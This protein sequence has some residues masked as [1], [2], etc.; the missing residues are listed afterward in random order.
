MKILKID[1]CDIS[2]LCSNNP[3]IFSKID[4]KVSYEWFYIEI[5]KDDLHLVCILSYKDCFNLDK[6]SVEQQSIYFTLYKGKKIVAYSYVYFDDE[7][8]KNYKE[9]LDQWLSGKNSVFSFWIP[10]HSLKKFININI[11]YEFKQNSEMSKLSEN[12]EGHFWQFIDSGNNLSAV[13]NIYNV[14][15]EF[16]FSHLCKRNSFFFDYP[17]KLKL[18]NQN[19]GVFDFK[20]ASFYF[21][22]NYGYSPLYSIKEPWYWWHEII[23]N[24]T[25]VNYYF[26]HLESMYQVKKTNDQSKYSYTYEISN[27]KEINIIKKF[28]FNIFGIKYP[29]ILNLNKEIVYDFTLESAP[30]YHRVKSFELRSTLEVLYPKKIENLFNQTLIKSRKIKIIKNISSKNEIRSYLNFSQICKKITYNHGKSFYISSLVLGEKQRNSSYF[31]YVLCRLIDDAT[32]E[33]NCFIDSSKIGSTFSN[34]IL[35]YLWSECDLLSDD[36]IE[37]FIQHLSNKVFSLVNYDSAIDFILSAR[38][39]IK[40]LELEKSYFI[41]LINGQKMDENFVQ[42]LNISDLYLYCFRVAGVVGIMMAKIFHAKNNLIAM[43]A[44]EKLGCAMQI[45]NILRDIKE[46]YENNRIYIPAELFSKYKIENFSLL[47][48]NNYESIKK[49]NLINELVNLAILYYCEAIEG[50][51]YIPSFRARLCV[52][53]MIGVYGSILGKI[54]FDKSIVFK[55]RIVISHFKKLIIFFKILFGFHPLKVANLINEKELL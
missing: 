27:A 35:E 38:I 48:S 3:I 53:L 32:D 22:H 50:L 44:A 55:Q 54:V 41:D 34:E 45:T 29:K 52:K 46:D 18:Q 51:K 43:N 12:N 30:F 9:E 49:N 2:L 37:T 36:F 47:F 25:Q 6:N 24:G 5:M 10:D 26:P 13:V 21:D 17:L 15:E 28:K 19:Y 40:E 31:I 7:S 42:P 1:N 20:K 23:Q 8:N 4:P 16:S 14:S 11:K 39:L 33:R